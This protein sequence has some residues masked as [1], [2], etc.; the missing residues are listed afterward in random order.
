MIHQYQLNGYNIVLDV[1]SGAVYSVDEAVYAILSGLGENAADLPDSLPTGL[2]QRL[3]V[4]FSEDKL[5]EAYEEIQS[6]YKKDLLYAKPE[7]IDLA[8]YK[9]E[10]TPIKAACLHIA[11]DCN[12][13]C[14][15]CFAG[16]GEYSG[17]RSMMSAETGKRALDFLIKHS[18][19]RKN[20]EVDFFGGEP[21]LNFS[22][23]KEIV[24]YG[25]QLEKGTDKRFRFTI[26][27]NG[28]KL[29]EEDIAYINANMVNAVLSI[30]GRKEVNDTMR[31][32]VDGSGSYDSILP[33]FKKI[34]DARNQRN[35]Y[36]RGTFTRKNLDFY[37]DVQ[38]LADEG[39]QQISIE[40]VAAPEGRDYSLRKEDLPQIF[41]SYEQIARSMLSGKIKSNFFH[42]MIDLSQGPC[43]IKRL[44][45]CGSG[46]EYIA[47]TPEGDIYPCHQFV[48][49]DGF[50]MGNVHTG[51]LDQTIKKRFSGYSIYSKPE[52]NS[53]WAKYFC[54]GGCNANNYLY[55]GDISKPYKLGCELEKKRVECAVMMKVAKR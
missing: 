10:N 26:T 43:I 20:I 31:V 54:S 53:C 17:K 21:T 23:V 32:R 1:E 52:C 39:F 19:Q 42:F 41:E 28:L 35:Y 14:K 51:E 12:L 4:D 30:D 34:A 29:S 8:K 11:H 9:N 40:P 38:H 6:L 16:T 18:D 44:R 36:V 33:K 48:G 24:E 37:K 25:R 2:F 22:A 45:G 47:V 46:C 7:K 55:E 3:S 13:R 49:L 27:T 50:K 15:Y 5:K